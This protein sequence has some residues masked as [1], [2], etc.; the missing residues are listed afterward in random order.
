[1]EQYFEHIPYFLLFVGMGVAVNLLR[2][3]G[4]GEKLSK[5]R[6]VEEV[7]ASIWI[8]LLVAGG[9]DYFTEWSQFLIYGV[10][11]AA[12]Y[13]NSILID[14]VGRGLVEYLLVKGRKVLDNFTDTEG[15]DSE[16]EEVQE[17]P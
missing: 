14:K 10:S 1:M 6:I 5:I 16:E 15:E 2:K 3:A 13:F 9:L 4:K 8:A 12:G 11:S 17:E 7:I